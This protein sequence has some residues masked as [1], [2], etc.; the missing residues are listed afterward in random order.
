MRDFF[1]ALKSER[2]NTAL[3]E[4]FNY[5]GKLIGSWQIK[6]VESDN[7][8]LIKGEWHFPA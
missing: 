4:E 3:P 1:E 2:K 8:R 7:S 6:Y 5:F